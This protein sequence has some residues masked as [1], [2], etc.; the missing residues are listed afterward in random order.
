VPRSK[1]R[2]DVIRKAW[3]DAEQ[4]LLDPETK[5]WLEVPPGMKFSTVDVER[6]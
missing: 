2:A 1:E 6:L 4:S 3:K 5:L